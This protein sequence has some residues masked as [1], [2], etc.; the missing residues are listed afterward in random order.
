[1]FKMRDQILYA[2]KDKL[3]IRLVK[4]APLPYDS[5]RI[6]IYPLKSQRYWQNAFRKFDQT[7]P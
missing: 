2:G 4:T 3:E 1:M 5:A 6:L 7:I